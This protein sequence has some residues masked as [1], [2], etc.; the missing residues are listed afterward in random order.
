MQR[1]TAVRLYCTNKKIE[2]YYSD[3]QDI[4]YSVVFS[5]FEWVRK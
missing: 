4:V 1:R 3:G 2:N 5:C